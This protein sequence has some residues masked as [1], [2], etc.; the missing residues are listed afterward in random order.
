MKTNPLP[1]TN[2]SHRR[3]RAFSLVE[4]VIASG[5]AAMV[6]TVGALSFRVITSQQ[7]SSVTY[8]SIGIGKDAAV[9][10]YGKPE[11][12]TKID[13]YFAPNY[14][15]A[16]NADLMREQFNDDISQASAIYCLP[17]S[18]LSTVR[19]SSISLPLSTDGRSIDTP[20]KF[21]VLLE[22]A[23]PLL[24]SVHTPY[25]CYD[26]SESPNLSIYILQPSFSTAAETLIITA[27]YEIDLQA[28][29][30]PAGTYASVRRYSF[31]ILTDVYDVFYP[32]EEDATA[33][34]PLVINFERDIRIVSGIDDGKDMF[35]I[36]KQ[37]PFYFIWWPD[38]AVPSLDGDSAVTS[39][40][41]TDPRSIYATMGGRTSY[42]FTVPMFPAL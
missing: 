8:G 37:E 4:M 19:P 22:A 29:S 5:L 7:R 2:S 14:G 25:T 24:A 6:F 28:V 23:Y 27:I 31:S 38:P 9:N 21:R 42:M 3:Q 30:D 15:R 39:Y 13:A 34:N 1:I 18:G 16:T 40:P 10:Y 35:R 33:F 20:E 11:T 41:A 32:D 36:A 12:V 26:G 17:R